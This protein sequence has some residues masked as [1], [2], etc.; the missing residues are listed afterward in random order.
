[1][2]TETDK[3]THKKPPQ[4]E[5]PIDSRKPSTLRPSYSKKTQNSPQ[6]E[7]LTDPH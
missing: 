5:T 3:T 4:E 1:M 7:A 6:E 2:Y